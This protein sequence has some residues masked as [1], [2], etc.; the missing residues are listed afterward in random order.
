LVAVKEA[1][2]QQKVFEI[3]KILKKFQNDGGTHTAGICSNPGHNHTQAD[4]LRKYF[5]KFWEKT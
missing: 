5:S 4:R 1:K 2:Q 3:L